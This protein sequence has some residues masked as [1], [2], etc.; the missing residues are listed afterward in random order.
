MIPDLQVSVYIHTLGFI[1][2][3][4]SFIQQI[5]T[6]H[7]HVPVTFWEL[8]GYS[9]EQNVK[10]TKKL[11]PLMDF[12]CKWEETDTPPPSKKRKRKV[13]MLDRINAMEGQR[14]ALTRSTHSHITPFNSITAWVFYILYSH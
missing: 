14:F 7:V 1:T 2:H 9:R 12:I 10:K 13:Y 5:L 6:E 11:L 4:H 3:T 8:L